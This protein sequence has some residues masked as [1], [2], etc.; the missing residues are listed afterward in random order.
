MQVLEEL[1][2]AG[3]PDAIIKPESRAF[4]ST[5]VDVGWG[6]AAGIVD[7]SS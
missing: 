3:A 7:G 2:M 5:A 1:G 6:D 4:Q